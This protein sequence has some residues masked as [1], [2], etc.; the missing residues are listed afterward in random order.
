MMG[1]WPR[2]RSSGLFLVSGRC[3]S[4]AGESC[5]VSFA[6]GGWSLGIIYKI[7]FLI[8][9]SEKILVKVCLVGKSVKVST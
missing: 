6:A 4:Y 2:S 7:L 8:L 3:I 9:V 5:V 1:F